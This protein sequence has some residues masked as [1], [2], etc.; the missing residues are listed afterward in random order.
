M[1]HKDDK[2]NILIYQSQDETIAQRGCSFCSLVPGVFLTI[3]VCF[4]AWGLVP[5]P[6]PRGQLPSRDGRL[7]PILRLE[8]QEAPA[9]A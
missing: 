8:A 1:E 4:A 2:G 3:L 6:A 9:Y 5:F 7:A